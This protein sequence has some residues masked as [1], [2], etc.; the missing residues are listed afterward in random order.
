M[1]ERKS[2]SLPHPAPARPCIP[3]AD[4][5]ALCPCDSSYSDAQK[6]AERLERLR[7]DRMSRESEE[8][9]FMPNVKKAAAP[10][11]SQV[12]SRRCGLLTASCCLL[13]LPPGASWCLLPG[14]CCC[15]P[16]T[17]RGAG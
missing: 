11:P 6:R 3:S 12:R 4:F 10:R 9:T 13:L 8:L 16:P 5:P 7:A 17:E 1:S 14:A 15:A 2:P